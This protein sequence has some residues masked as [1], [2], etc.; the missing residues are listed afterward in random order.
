[1]IYLSRTPDNIVRNLYAERERLTLAGVLIVAAASLLGF[2][3][4]RTVSRPV[5]M[6]AHRAEAITRGDRAAIGPLRHYGTEELAALAQSF[7]LMAKRLSDRS[8]Y[9]STFASHVTHELKTPL[10]S[11]RGAAELMADA[12]ETMTGEARQRFLA[13]VAGDAE[14]MSALLDRLRELAR[15]DNPAL[16]GETTLGAVGEELRARF[17]GLTV[18]LQAA[19]E[20]VLPMSQENALIVFGNLLDNA[21]NHAAHEVVLRARQEDAKLVLSVLDDGSGVS[22][23]NRDRIFD[24]FFT[25]RRAEGGTGIGLGIVRALMRAHG[26]DIALGQSEKGALFEVAFALAAPPHAPRPI[27][28]KFQ[29]LIR[30]VIP[31]A[32]RDPWRARPRAISEP[33]DRSEPHNKSE[34]QNIGEAP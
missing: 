29:S 18:L 1:V 31:A 12:R 7:M 4:V 13:N 15:A 33:H 23:G 14:R 16:G 21:A 25:T 10:T 19:S 26:G 20:T 17:P 27:W 28:R 24:P 3:F 22:P 32:R 6:L 8:D 9:L 2:I 11:I 34:P 5:A 30:K